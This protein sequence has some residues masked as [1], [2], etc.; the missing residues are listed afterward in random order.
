SPSARAVLGDLFEPL[1]LLPAAGA[2]PDQALR[3]AGRVGCSRAGRS[4]AGRPRVPRLRA[5]SAGDRA[6]RTGRRD[7]GLL[8]GSSVPALVF[9]SLGAGEGPRHALSPPAVR[10]P[11]P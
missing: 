6:R 10:L 8:P 4:S 1:G 2:G 9:G 5:L 3:E 11:G 7:F